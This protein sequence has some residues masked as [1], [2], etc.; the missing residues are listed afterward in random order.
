MNPITNL[1]EEVLFYYFWQLMPNHIYTM[2]NRDGSI[3]KCKL[4]YFP[5][6]NNYKETETYSP[7]RVLIEVGKGDFREVTYVYI[8]K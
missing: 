5:I 7:P 3:V 2:R 1:K 8:E 6:R 4:V